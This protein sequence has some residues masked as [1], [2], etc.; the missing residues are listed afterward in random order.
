[1]FPGQES[2]LIPTS[3]VMPVLNGEQVYIVK[4]GLAQIC[5]IETGVRS[6]SAVEVIKGLNTGDS[7][8]LT[9]LLQIKPEQK[10][11]PAASKKQNQ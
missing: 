1:M 3:A 6:D 11:K 4:G 2:I 10:I 8:I 9:G 5:R 7:L